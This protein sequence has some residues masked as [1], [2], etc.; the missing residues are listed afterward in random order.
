MVCVSTRFCRR[1]VVIAKVALVNEVTYDSAPP[2]GSYT[3][4]RVGECLL[5]HNHNL[6]PE[7]SKY[8]T[9]TTIVT[10]STRVGLREGR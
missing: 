7:M 8:Q 6:F 9:D 4:Q 10:S 1:V 2:S 3:P 5:K